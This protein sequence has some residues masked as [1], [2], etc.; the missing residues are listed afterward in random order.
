MHTH[1]GAVFILNEI[2]SVPFFSS[3]GIDCAS[4]IAYR[5]REHFQGITHALNAKCSTFICEWG[6]EF[7]QANSRAQSGFARLEVAL[8]RT[9]WRAAKLL[10]EFLFSSVWYL[11]Y[12]HSEQP[13]GARQTSME[14]RLTKSLFNTY[15]SRVLTQQCSSNEIR[16]FSGDAELRMDWKEWFTW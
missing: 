7:A 14:K 4:L 1:T 11:L 5:A 6:A 16:F 8:A 9:D 10:Q 3:C 2:K 15:S 12:S 13:T